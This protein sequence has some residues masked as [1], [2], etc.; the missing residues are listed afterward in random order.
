MVAYSLSPSTLN[1]D[2]RISEL[3][4]SCLRSPRAT[5]PDSVKSKEVQSYRDPMAYFGL[6]TPC[7]CTGAHAHRNNWES[8]GCIAIICYSN[9]RKGSQDVATNSTPLQSET[10]AKSDQGPGTVAL[11]CRPSMRDL[12]ACLV[13]IHGELRV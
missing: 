3:E 2:R 6:N 13:Y 4:C 12:K 5:Q 7:S 11:A 1:A 8:T 10:I 9:T